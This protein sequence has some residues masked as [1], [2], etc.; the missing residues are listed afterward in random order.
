MK[1]KE[2]KKFILSNMVSM[3]GLLETRFKAINLGNLYLNLFTGWCFTTNIS[4][5]D[6]GR[7]SIGWNPT[8][9]NVDILKCTSQ[10]IHLKVRN[11]NQRMEFLATFVY[12]FNDVI[13]RKDL[14]KNLVDISSTQP[15]MVLGDF[16]DILAKEEI[17][18]KRVRDSN[19]SDFLHCVKNCQ[20]EDI[21][22]SRNFYTWSNK[23]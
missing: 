17:I 8:I 14:W 20:L 13:G 15:W 21:K 1:Q 11:I 18:G 7:I 3:I 9:F 22:Y 6:G 4:W 2:V 23:K 12:G 16:N 19:N 10:L 5:H